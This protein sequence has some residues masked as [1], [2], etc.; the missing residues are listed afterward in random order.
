MA[1]FQKVNEI[2]ARYFEGYYPA[3]STLHAAALPKY[4]LVEIELTAAGDN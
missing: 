3:K 2:Y 1:D 4:V